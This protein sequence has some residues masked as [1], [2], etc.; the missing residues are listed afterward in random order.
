M[1]QGCAHRTV[2][3][4]MVLTPAPI[5]MVAGCVSTSHSRDGGAQTEHQGVGLFLPPARL[6][7]LLNVYSMGF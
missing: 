1:H 5:L 6:P 3:G 4:T 7:L 2:L